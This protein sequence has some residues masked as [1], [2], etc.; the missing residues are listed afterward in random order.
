M[1]FKSKQV[2]LDPNP[3][4]SEISGLRRPAPTDTNPSI[5]RYAPRPEF[6]PTRDPYPW[7]NRYD[8]S[9]W[10]D[11]GIDLGAVMPGAGVLDWAPRRDQFDTP[12]NP[13]LAEFRKLWAGQVDMFDQA[14]ELADNL[15]DVDYLW[16]LQ[17]DTDYTP[18]EVTHAR[19]V[20]ERLAAFE[21]KE[22]TK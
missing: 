17:R 22:A 1:I 18:N 6:E 7:R 21:S 15:G 10:A 19:K 13:V 3:Y 9:R 5:W 11:P 12:V 8:G 20:L 2:N 14:A 4:V 16:E